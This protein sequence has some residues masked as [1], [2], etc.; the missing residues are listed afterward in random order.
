MLNKQQLT[1]VVK[2]SEINAYL[3]IVLNIKQLKY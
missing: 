1:F 3:F 2:K